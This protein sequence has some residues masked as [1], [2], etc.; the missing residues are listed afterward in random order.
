MKAIKYIIFFLILIPNSYYGQELHEKL[1]RELCKCVEKQKLEKIEDIE[2]CMQ[3][4]IIDNAEK[5]L[6]FHNVKLITDL[7]ED[8]FVDI[9]AKFT[10]NC[11]Y[12]MRLIKNP[13]KEKMNNDTSEIF[14]KCNE[15]K[16][17]EYY[18][19]VAK[20]METT[21]MDTTFVTITKTHFYERMNSGKTYSNLKIHWKDNCKFDLEFVESNDSF[22]KNLSKPG[23]IYSYEIVRTTPDSVYLKI[24]YREVEFHFEL[25]K[26]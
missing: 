5:L 11:D 1:A 12:A 23:E 13:I 21:Q 2:I 17:G 6:K 15:F 24:L 7:S 26:I 16:E 20:G 3:T 10:K 25:I 18:Y 22:K 19:L 9:G 4:L 14:L 8:V